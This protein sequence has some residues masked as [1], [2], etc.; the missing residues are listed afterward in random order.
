MF[1]FSDTA[2]R[3]TK[4]IPSQNSFWD[5]WMFFGLTEPNHGSNPSWMEPEFKE[6]EIKFSSKWS[7]TLD[8]QSSLCGH[9]H[10]VGQQKRRGPYTWP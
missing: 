4:E 3:T 5:L 6:W 8:I 7:Q 9:S 1:L 10:S 2:V